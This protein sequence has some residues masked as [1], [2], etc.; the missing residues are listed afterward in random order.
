MGLEI[1]GEIGEEICGLDC[2]GFG[3]LKVE[4]SSFDLGKMVAMMIGEEI[5]GGLGSGENGDFDRGRR[6]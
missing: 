5:G 2:D 6:R 3:I 4:Q 1:A